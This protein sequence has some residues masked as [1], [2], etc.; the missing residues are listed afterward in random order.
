M[1]RFELRNYLKELKANLQQTPCSGL[2]KAHIIFLRQ[3][4]IKVQLL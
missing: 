3:K 4:K 2:R 1:E